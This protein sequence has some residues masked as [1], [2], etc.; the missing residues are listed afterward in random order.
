[1]KKSIKILLVIIGVLLIISLIALCIWL[2]KANQ[3]PVSNNQTSIT[4][5][6]EK[7]EIYADAFVGD[8]NVSTDLI[9]DAKTRLDMVNYSLEKESNEIC[10][11]HECFVSKDVHKQRYLELFGENF[12]YE[13]DVNS[14]KTNGNCDD[15]K[16]N[17]NYCF[18]RRNEKNTLRFEIISE[19]VQNNELR[20]S[21]KYSMYSNKGESLY[22]GECI[23]VYSLT[24][25]N[26]S[27]KNIIIVS[28]NPGKD[29][30]IN[31]KEMKDVARYKEFFMRTLYESKTPL[32]EENRL[33][34]AMLLANGKVKNVSDP[35]YS[36]LVYI[37]KDDYKTTYDS[38]FGGNYSFDSDITYPNLS[39]IYNC[40]M[41]KSLEN[42]NAVCF[43]GTY[44]YTQDIR[45]NEV[46]TERVDKD[47]IVKIDFNM[48]DSFTKKYIYG[49]IT[50]KYT[51][52]DNYGFLKNITA[53]Y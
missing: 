12:N 32:N 15:P 38:I 25:N 48:N 29:V 34:L 27:I 28:K 47:Y 39:I 18:Y 43:N 19:Q 44:N 4:V 17:P 49:I 9:K 3:K 46:T 20:V 37:L 21:T 41:V 50:M 52:K 24:N 10:D 22:E 1:M 45:L 53:E 2:S 42:Q 5:S 14:N 40:D 16:H 36:E 33:L 51:I 26:P 8:F 31:E 23:Y 11:N 13:D 6:K 30:I 35:E 7:L